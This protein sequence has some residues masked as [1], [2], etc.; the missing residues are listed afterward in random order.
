MKRLVIIF[1]FTLFILS[2]CEKRKPE[3]EIPLPT[4]PPNLKEMKPTSSPNQ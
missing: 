3:V 2:A 1:L 4:E